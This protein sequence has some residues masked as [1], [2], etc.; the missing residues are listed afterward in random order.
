MNWQN[1]DPKWK[2]ASITAAIPGWIR[3]KAAQ[4]WI[5]NWKAQ[6]ANGGKEASLA[7]FKEFMAQQD[8]PIDPQEELAGYTRHSKNGIASITNITVAA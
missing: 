3:F 4:E 5:D 2:E 6:Q 7:N 1:A 8:A